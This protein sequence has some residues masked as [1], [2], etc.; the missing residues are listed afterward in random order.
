MYNAYREQDFKVDVNLWIDIERIDYKAVQQIRD[1]ATHSRVVDHMAVMPDVHPGYG[2]PV[3]TIW[4]TDQAVVPY[5]VGVDIGCV[6]AETEYMSP[7]GWV[8]I[9]DYVDGPV[10]AYSIKTGNAQFENPS[11]YINEKCEEFLWIKT[12]YGVD[13][14]VTPDHKIF[15][16]SMFGRDRNR[17][18]RILTAQELADWHNNLSM[19]ANFEFQTSFNPE[20]MEGSSLTYNQI[21][22]QVMVNADGHIE[23]G[24][25]GR[26]RAYVNLKKTR[27]IDRC[28]MLL[29]NENIAY[30]ESSR[31]NGCV[32][33]SFVPPLPE[34]SFDEFWKCTAYEL[35]VIS[36]ECL[37]WDGNIKDQCFFSRNKD[38]ADFIHYAFAASGHRSVMRKDIDPE[39]GID[40]RV[41]RY[42][43]S[44]V[45]LKSVTPREIENIHI[46][47]GRKYCFTLPSEFWV[48]RRGGNI[49]I[50]GNCGMLAVQTML[51]Y[52]NDAVFWNDWRERVLSRVPV[53]HSG[54]LPENAHDNPVLDRALSN[55]DLQETFHKKAALQL[56][57][58]GGGNHFMEASYDED[59]N[60][61]FIV[62]S[63]S[64]GIGHAIATYHTRAAK[65]FA[66]K[67]HARDAIDLAF[68]DLD[69]EGGSSYLH[70]MVWA[71]EY[72]YEN[73]Q[74]MMRQML[75]ALS[76]VIDDTVP[77]YG[78][79][80]TPH[81]YAEVDNDKIIT[82]R[83][84]ATEVLEQ[85]VVPGSMGTPSFIV[86][87]LPNVDAEPNLW[88]CSH[89]AGRMMGRKAFAENYSMEDFQH[90][91]ASTFTIANSGWID[92]SPDAYKNIY[93]VMAMQ[94]DIIKI[95]HTLHPIITLKGGGKD[96]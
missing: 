92:E 70:D 81:N 1:G 64:R 7:I 84:G 61:W 4:R 50:T 52:K 88:S 33:F 16:Y 71:Q 14:M 49:V 54:H 91:L 82:Y 69:S 90:S 19:G 24:K 25:R 95:D 29:Q 35:M 31:L 94:E 65:E 47:N 18:E 22:I 80:D 58:L 75:Y 56:G 66:K 62:H 40:Y 8:K 59:G 34:K 20:N 79:I 10:L 53:G 87:P 13:Q 38:F 83:K 39:G 2:L 57:S 46:P 78:P 21:R 51:R 43:E 5:A 3:G 63:G 30:T 12:K 15:G 85:A 41:F 93:E 48:M 89:G 73:R 67:S 72:A 17:I 86:S 26:C 96:D 11:R 27:K 74:I 44:K 23:V 68:M 55:S 36:D 37:Y 42:D 28:R 60:L 9:S 32:C 77:A 45:G 76:E 6:D